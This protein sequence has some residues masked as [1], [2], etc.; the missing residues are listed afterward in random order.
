MGRDEG[1][2]EITEFEQDKHVGLKMESRRFSGTG[3]LDVESVDGGTRLS[4]RFGGNLKGMVW[5]LLT[6]L[7]MPMIKRSGNKDFRRLK[8][9]LE[10]G[11]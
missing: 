10:S 8:G 5:K 6:P 3:Q 1:V 2:F 7:M 11:S 4:Y 9:I